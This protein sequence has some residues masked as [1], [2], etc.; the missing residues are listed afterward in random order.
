MSAMTLGCSLPPSMDPEVQ[1]R[2]PLDVP[3]EEDLLTQPVFPLIHAIKSDIE[4]SLMCEGSSCA[5][6]QV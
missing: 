1:I 4:V 5:E 3:L 6:L 2:M